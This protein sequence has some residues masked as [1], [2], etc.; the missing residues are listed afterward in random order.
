[1]MAILHHL[2]KQ[3]VR[4]DLEP[5]KQRTQKP[6]KPFSNMASMPALQQSLV[7]ALMNSFHE[8]RLF[9]QRMVRMHTTALPS[10]ALAHLPSMALALYLLKE[11]TLMAVKPRQW[12]I[13]KTGIM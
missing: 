5:S 8:A 12:R 3:L 1:M 2:M 4:Q 6:R 13:E 7:A 10:Q 9:Y 11:D